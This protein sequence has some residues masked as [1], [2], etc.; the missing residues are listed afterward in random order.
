MTLVCQGYPNDYLAK[1]QERLSSA[2]VKVVSFPAGIGVAEAKNVGIALASGEFVVFVDDD[3]EMG[4]DW[5]EH[6]LRVLAA[7]SPGGRVLNRRDSEW[8]ARDSPGEDNC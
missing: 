4:P 1:L 5:L 2:R 8:R 3:V 6:M 7:P